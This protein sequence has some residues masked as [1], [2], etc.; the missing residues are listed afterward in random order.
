M[1][2]SDKLTCEDNNKNISNFFLFCGSISLTYW[3]ELLSTAWAIEVCGDV[4]GNGSNTEIS[5]TLGRV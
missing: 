3:T 5:E 1:L 2:C 4:V